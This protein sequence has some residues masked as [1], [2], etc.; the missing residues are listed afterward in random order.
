M[1]GPMSKNR[2]IVALVAGLVLVIVG[3]AGGVS[4]KVAGCGVAPYSYA[5]VQAGTTARGVAATLTSTNAPSVIDGHVGGWVGV[6]GPEA[7][8]NGEAEWLQVGLSAFSSDNTAQIYYE[9]AT[10]GDDPQYVEVSSGIAAGES[11]KFAVLEMAKRKDFWR[12][13]VDGKPVSGPVYLPGS[14][15]SWYPQAIAENWNG[16]TGAC[17]SYSFKFT[18]VSLAQRA[19]GSWRS[20]KDSVTLA[21]TGY[22]VVPISHAPMSF[23][24]ASIG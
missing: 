17:N 20:L 11:H 22:R 5:G 6:G 15:G 3:P 21:D 16:A 24:A 13:W 19:G 2:S 9:V 8:P 7:G 1:H 12:V 18:D 23:L 10:P 14:D 4:K